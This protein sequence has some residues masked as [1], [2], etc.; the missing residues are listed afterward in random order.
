MRSL[1]TL[2]ALSAQPQSQMQA[3]PRMKTKEI[4]QGLA[5]GFQRRCCAQ[6]TLAPERL[7][8]SLRHP[9]DCRPPFPICPP[10]IRLQKNSLHLRRNKAQRGEIIY[11]RLF[12]GKASPSTKPG[13]SCTGR[14]FPA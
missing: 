13:Y 3:L 6:G 5:A 8:A 7:C 12:R 10:A 11:T 4:D 9:A 1:Q 2:C 14:L